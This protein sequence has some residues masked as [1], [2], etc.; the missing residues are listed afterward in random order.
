[1]PSRPRA[2]SLAWWQGERDPASRGGL[3]VTDI[4][5]SLHEDHA[6]LA[7]LLG[8]LERQL[9]LFDEGESPDYDIVRGVVDYCLDDQAL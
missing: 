7:K 6:N 8:A 5:D 2:D 4:I 3:E 1:M 9:A